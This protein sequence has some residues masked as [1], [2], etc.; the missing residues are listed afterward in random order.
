LGQSYIEGVAAPQPVL[1]G[2]EGSVAGQLG[3]DR[4]Q[5]GVGQLLQKVYCLRR[6]LEPTSAAGYRSSNLW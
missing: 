4:H 1:T 5:P 3:D 2:E 6:Q